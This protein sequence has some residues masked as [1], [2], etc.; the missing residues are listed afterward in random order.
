MNTSQAAEAIGVLAPAPLEQVIEIA[1]SP[2]D[3]SERGD[4]EQG[5]E[6]L[7]VNLEPDFCSAV[8]IVPGGMGHC[9]CRVNQDEEEHP[10]PCYDV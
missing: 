8:I 3:Q 10:T 7:R 9:R 4:T 2:R 5:C 1:E 6:D